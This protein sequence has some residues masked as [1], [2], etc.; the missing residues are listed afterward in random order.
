MK[1]KAARLFVVLLGLYLFLFNIFLTLASI[2]DTNSMAIAA[3]VWGLMIVWIVCAGALMYI[4]RDRIRSVVQCIPLPWQVT[5][6]LGA[7]ALALIEEAVTVSLTNMA[8]L[9][10][11]VAGEAYITATTNYVD[12]V[13]FHSVII[14]IPLFIAWSIVLSKYRFSPFSVF[15]LFGITGILCEISFGGP[16]Q[17][18][19][20]AQ[21]IF[22]YGLMIYLPAYSI[23]DNRN[24]KTVRLWHYVAAIPATLLIALP[25]LIPIVYVITKIL[26]HPSIH[27]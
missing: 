15:L 8:P 26:Q 2:G 4:F 11:A 16:Q 1:T 6:V 5:F 13:L 25:M 7:T 17:V 27:F 14:F 20:F 24:A 3:M 23:P 10:G 9:F 22:V 12:L 18:L 19:G 21:W